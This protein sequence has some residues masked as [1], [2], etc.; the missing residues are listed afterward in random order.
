MRKHSPV[1]PLAKLWRRCASRTLVQIFVRRRSRSRITDTCCRLWRSLR[2]IGRASCFHRRS[3][4]WC[5]NFDG[6]CRSFRGWRSTTLLCG[7]AWDGWSLGAG[8]STS[9]A[10][11]FHFQDQQ[12]GIAPGMLWSCRPS[13]TP[14]LLAVIFGR[15]SSAAVVTEPFCGSVPRAGTGGDWPLFGLRVLSRCVIRD[16]A[17]A[18]GHQASSLFGACLMA[19]LHH[20]AFSTAYAHRV[21]IGSSFI[22]PMCWWV[23]RLKGMRTTTEDRW[24]LW[25]C[26]LQLKHAYRYLL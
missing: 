3:S 10:N 14:V 2:L 25:A 13:R 20:Q 4:E 17:S 18:A 19:W 1:R 16:R 7:Y 15:R 5:E 24:K 26:F 9:W 8:C 21:S 23:R 6:L 12:G 22:L 11:G